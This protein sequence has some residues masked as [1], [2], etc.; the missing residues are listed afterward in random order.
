MIPQSLDE[1][2]RGLD[3]ED[4]GWHGWELDE[5]L[6]VVRYGTY[7]VA[8]DQCLTA[9]GCVFWIVQIAGK[10]WGTPEVV[11]GLVRILD[12]VFDMQTTMC[13]PERQ[14]TTDELTAR[15]AIVANKPRSKC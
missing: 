14:M 15:I 4:P 12:D 13:H 7:C 3:D 2:F 6:R 10:G 5:E 11:S 8:L 9:S 1:V